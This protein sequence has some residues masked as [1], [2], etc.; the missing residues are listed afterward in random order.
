MTL[1]EIFADKYTDKVQNGL[2]QIYDELFAPI[3]EDVELMLE[4]GVD[5]GGSIEGWIEYFP[6][7]CVFGIDKNGPECD[8]I[9]ERFVMWALDVNAIENSTFYNFR[10]FD[11]IIDDGSHINKEVFHAFEILWPFVKPGGYYIVEDIQVPFGDADYPKIEVYFESFA[12]LSGWKYEVPQ[13]NLLWL[14]KEE[15]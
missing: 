6:N 14:K 15:A 11:I 2:A 5:R 4:I 3:R 9:H 12:R 1:V 8:F 10:P 7:A 13:Y